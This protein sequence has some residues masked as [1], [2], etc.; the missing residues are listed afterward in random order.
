MYFSCVTALHSS[1]NGHSSIMSRIFWAVGFMHTDPHMWA[2]SLFFPLRLSVSVC[3]SRQRGVVV[4]GESD[5]ACKQIDWGMI[6]ANTE[7]HIFSQVR[8]SPRALYTFDSHPVW[9]S[10][11]PP[12]FPTLLLL[13]SGLSSA[14]LLS[15]LLS[16]PLLSSPP[17]PSGKRQQSSPK[18]PTDLK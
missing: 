5:E 6:A 12:P 2:S 15:P 7:S 3:H 8:L 11:P 1:V 4:W 10:D 13:S 9:N 18:T 17:G 16:S 14:P